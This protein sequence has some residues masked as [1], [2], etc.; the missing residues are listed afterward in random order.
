MQIKILGPLEAT[1]NGRSTLPTAAKPR[2]I[3]A[4]LAL[5]AGQVVPVT[6][7]IEELWGE[8]PPRSARTTLQTYI[9]QLRRLLGDNASDV[10]VTRFGG[11]LLNVPVENVDVH[12]FERLAA[13]GRRASE[14]GDHESA[15]RLLG[16][17]LGMWLGPALV[18]T[19]TGD[20]LSIEATRLE[21]SRLSVV[22]SRIDA[23]MLVGR[24][25]TLLSELAVLTA[26]HPMN[27]N[28]CA[29]YMVALFR[30]GRQWQAL[31]AFKSLRQTLIEE[32]GVE[33]SA[34]LRELHR[35]VLTADSSLDRVE[36]SEVR[37]LLA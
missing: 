6:T 36:T 17:A 12:E 28:L 8:R 31:D 35:A 4:L 26:R 34:R 11:Y 33:P 25:H 37:Q 19:P 20:V 22:E 5:R 1:R 13:A 2:Q 3:F 32:L 18:D 9:M 10:L 27:E 30:S 15:A 7:L 21:E 24:H 14:A 23:E 29:Q 16:T